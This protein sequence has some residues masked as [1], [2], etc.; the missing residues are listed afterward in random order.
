MQFR[1]KRR[2]QDS[3]VRAVRAAPAE[4]HQVG[5]P[6]ADS[7]AGDREA[8]AAGEAAV[9]EDAGEA[10]KAGR[11]ELQRCGARSA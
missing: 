7:L 10:L 11:K 8:V 4:A 5:D 9:V 2:P 6:P 1:V 3:A